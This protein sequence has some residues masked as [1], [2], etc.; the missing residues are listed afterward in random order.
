MHAGITVEVILLPLRDS[1]AT[2][3][4]PRGHMN[5]TKLILMP[6]KSCTL[7]N[8]STPILTPIN[9]I[10]RYAATDHNIAGNIDIKVPA[11]RNNE[12]AAI[13]TST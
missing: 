7:K 8:T 3:P 13:T 4:I 5:F 6:V 11:A 9:S 10:T 1:A 2:K 12:H